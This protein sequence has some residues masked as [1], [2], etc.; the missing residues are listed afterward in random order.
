MG[1]INHKT[2]PICGHN[3]FNRKYN[4]QDYTVSKEFFDIQQCEACGFMFT[5]DAPDATEIGPYYKSD[6]YV[7]HSNTKKGL[8]FKV[9]HKV[10][11]YMLNQ[12]RKSIIKNSSSVT[13]GQTILDIGTGRGYFLNHMQQHGYNCVGIE[14][15]A[16][17]RALAS[18]EFDLNILPPEDL[19]KL[20]NKQFD[21]ITLWHVLEHV[22]DLRAYLEKI[23]TLLKPKGLL[24]IALPNPTCADE[25]IYKEHWAGWDVPI[26][27]WHFTP[28]NIKDLLNQYQFEMIDKAR[29]PFDPFYVSILGSQQR[30]DVFPII[31]GG[32]NGLRSYTKCLSDIDK[33]TSLIYFFKENK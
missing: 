30:G 20:E 7:S 27:L 5:Q 19:Y 15:D 9:Y 12:K 11:E 2:C 10:R 1:K 3:I 21:V 4:L 25:A 13:K 31:Q 14:Q 26:H 28:N 24:V 32:L 33:T 23:K 16:E 6:D 8:F 22:H 29:L 17:V 18:K